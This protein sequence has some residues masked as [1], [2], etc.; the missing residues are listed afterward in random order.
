MTHSLFFGLYSSSFIWVLKLA[1]CAALLLYILV[2]ILFSVLARSW[3]AGIITTILALMFGFIFAPWSSLQPITT[4]NPDTLTLNPYFQ[5]LAY[6]WMVCMASSL[7]SIPGNL[8]LSQQF[9]A[10]VR[11]GRNPKAWWSP[12]TWI[13]TSPMEGTGRPR[14]NYSRWKSGPLD[15][16]HSIRVKSEVKPIPLKTSRS[17]PETAAPPSASGSKPAVSG[18]NEG[19]ER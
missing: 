5:A 15:H 9:G 12:G 1:L 19:S 14:T 6:L 18:Q 2:A 10:P 4:S 8:W 11:R 13:F 3:K 16:I 7:G 17:A